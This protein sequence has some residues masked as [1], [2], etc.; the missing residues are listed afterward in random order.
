MSA[1][2]PR[3]D[4]E[5]ELNTEHDGHPAS[6]TLYAEMLP[7][8]EA[9]ATVQQAARRFGGDADE[10]EEIADGFLRWRAGDSVDS[11]PVAER[12]SDSGSD[13]ALEAARRRIAHLE[14]ENRA[15]RRRLS[16]L[17]ELTDRA[18]GILDAG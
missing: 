13:A 6:P 5:D 9:G 14:D 17:R 18:R 10:V 8:V 15:L 3:S 7:L 11:P 1:D 4:L 12:S 16:D 2:D